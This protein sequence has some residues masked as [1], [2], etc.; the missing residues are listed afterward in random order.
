[1]FVKL[2]TKLLKKLLRQFVTYRCPKTN[3]SA[4]NIWI[5]ARSCFRNPYADR[6]S[7]YGRGKPV[8]EQQTFIP[9]LFNDGVEALNT[10]GGSSE[11][12]FKAWP[13]TQ[14]EKTTTD[15]SDSLFFNA[16]LRIVDSPNYRSFTRF[17]VILSSKS[18]SDVL[19]K[20]VELVE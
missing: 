6:R 5:E 9:G 4:D 17:E 7:C 3:C 19:V 15:I 13:L 2:E 16:P 14:T 1:M 18:L 8:E 12:H 20:I 11:N 10:S